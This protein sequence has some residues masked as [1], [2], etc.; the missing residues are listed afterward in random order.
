MLVVLRDSNEQIKDLMKEEDKERQKCEPRET[1]YVDFDKLQNII[2]STSKHLSAPPSTFYGRYESTFPYDRPRYDDR[3]VSEYDNCI[4]S[5]L[6]L[7]KSWLD[8]RFLQ[9]KIRDA[10]V[11]AVLAQKDIRSSV[12]GSPTRYAESQEPTYYSSK[13]SFSPSGETWLEELRD[14]RRQHSLSSTEHLRRFSDSYEKCRY[15]CDGSRSPTSSHSI[16][17]QRSVYGR[18]SPPR[19][20]LQTPPE[21]RKNGSCDSPLRED[22]KRE[23]GKSLKSPLTFS[24]ATFLPLNFSKKSASFFARKSL[25]ALFLFRYCLSQWRPLTFTL[26]WDPQENGQRQWCVETL[27]ILENPLHHRPLNNK[28]DIFTPFACHIFSIS[29]LFTVNTLNTPRKSIQPPKKVRVTERD[30][31][32]S[33]PVLV[34]IIDTY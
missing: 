22:F 27:L 4:R 6:S 12:F 11:D 29:R 17:S 33:W 8:E 32:G 28:F 21:L 5:S 15:Y 34:L 31:F 3:R 9:D 7:R 10:E 20:I 2:L 26:C 24:K 16:G 14:S 23:I 18:R 25:W 1:S 19:T 13:P 30:S